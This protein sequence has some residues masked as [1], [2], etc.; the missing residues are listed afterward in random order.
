MNYNGKN[1]YSNGN[2]VNNNNEMIIFNKFTP[3][4]FPNTYKVMDIKKFIEQ[5]VQLR[6]RLIS[7]LNDIRQK[8]VANNLNNNNANIDQR[9]MTPNK[10]IN[11]RHSR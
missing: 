7:E 6:K 1:I 2:N 4:L 9:A 8:R 3:N 10:H 11:N 5:N